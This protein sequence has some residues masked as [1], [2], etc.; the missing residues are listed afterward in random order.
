M[1]KRWWEID[2]RERFR[3]CRGT[4]H[5]KCASINSSRNSSRWIRDEWFFPRGTRVAQNHCPAANFLRFSTCRRSIDSCCFFAVAADW[6]L[7]SSAAT[8]QKAACLKGAARA[9]A[10][11]NTFAWVEPAAGAVG[12]STHSLFYDATLISE[13]DNIFLSHTTTL[14]PTMQWAFA[15]SSLLARKIANWYCFWN[16]YIH[17]CSFVFSWW[18]LFFMSRDFYSK[19][20]LL[21]IIQ[22]KAV[23]LSF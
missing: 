6:Q 17:W 22:M 14:H 18:N 5:A 12:F 7:L 10:W 19:R 15:S 21:Y 4:F 3:I 16:I 13:P 23:V 2:E 11:K 1:W 8:M 9:T 20:T